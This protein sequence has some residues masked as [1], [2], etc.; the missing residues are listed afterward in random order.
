MDLI[1]FC[2][3]PPNKISKN[4]IL[5]YTNIDFSNSIMPGVYGFPDFYDDDTIKHLT[6]HIIDIYAYPFGQSYSMLFKV[7]LINN[8]SKDIKGIYEIN[9]NIIYIINNRYYLYNCTLEEYYYLI[10]S[11][12]LH[13]YA[14][15]QKYVKSLVIDNNKYFPK[16]IVK[17]GDLLLPLLYIIKHQKILPKVLIN[18]KIIPYIYS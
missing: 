10:K 3:N 15:Y 16:N 13:K 14:N 12:E 7:L 4:N 2:T 5:Q 8:K 18:H 9:N 17:Y 1:D 6:N 11:P